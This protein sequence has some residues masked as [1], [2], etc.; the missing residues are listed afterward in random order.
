MPIREHIIK[1]MGE[2]TPRWE[3]RAFGR[4]FGEAE[5]QLAAL[6]PEGMQECDEMYLLTGTAGNVKVRNALLDIKVMKQVNAQDLQ[7]WMPVMK[8]GFPLPATQVAQVFQALQLPVPSLSRASYELGEF[9]REFAPPG[10][11]IRAVKVHKRRTHYTL[12]G[13]MAELADVIA[14]GNRTRTI[15]VESENAAAVISTVRM[16]V[17]GAIRTLA[18]PLA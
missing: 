9:I 2:I 7:L 6:T 15:A 10:S 14:N 12:G 1:H 17:W 3:W 18:I 5:A 11:A 8:A 13:C 4:R 16:L